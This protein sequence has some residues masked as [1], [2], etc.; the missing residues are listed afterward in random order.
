MKGYDF[1]ID[2]WSFG[3]CL[4]EMVVGNPPY[5]GTNVIEMRAQ[6]MQDVPMKD[7]FSKNFSSLIEGLLQ[8]NPNHRLTIPQIKEHPFFKKVKWQDVIL[9]QQK[10]PIKPKVKN[11]QDINNFD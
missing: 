9:C 4:Y 7:Y 11:E 10:A 6:F 3:C 1:A 8:K 5:H 2:I